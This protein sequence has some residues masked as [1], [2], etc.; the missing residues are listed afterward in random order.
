MTEVVRI[1]HAAGS[2]RSYQANR[3]GNVWTWAPGQP[4]GELRNVTRVELFRAGA[5]SPCLVLNADG[6][7]KSRVAFNGTT[8][9]LKLQLLCPAFQ[10]GGPFPNNRQGKFEFLAELA[11]QIFDGDDDL[12]WITFTAAWAQAPLPATATLARLVSAVNVN[13]LGRGFGGDNALRAQLEFRDS[14]EYPAT[15]EVALLLRHVKVGGVVKYLVG[16]SPLCRF[17]ARLSVCGHDLAGDQTWLEWVQPA[18]DVRRREPSDEP[19]STR[20]WLL[21]V[22]QLNGTHALWNDLVHVPYTT[23]LVTVAAGEDAT[24]V[25]LINAAGASAWSLCFRF[26]F[27][28]ATSTRTEKRL[29]LRV[30]PFVTDSAPID[31]CLPGLPLVDDDRD[32]FSYSGYMADADDASA[33]DE[34]F[35]LHYGWSP[36]FAQQGGD[37]DEVTLLR[38]RIRDAEATGAAGALRRTRFGALD[39]SVETGAALKLDAHAYI[40][41]ARLGASGATALLSIDT[42]VSEADLADVMPGAEDPLPDS[43]RTTLDSQAR[44]GDTE[45]AIRSLL[46]PRSAL[47][48][49]VGASTAR[50]PAILE[51]QEQATR[52]TSR[53]MVLRLRRHRNASGVDRSV[54]YLSTEPFLLAKVS[55]PNLVLPPAD[56]DEIANWSLS[57]QE[58]RKWEIATASEGFDLMLPPQAVGEAMEKS[59]AQPVIND[60]Q[61]VDFRFSAPAQFRLGSTW[62]TQGYA[63]APWNLSRVLGYPGQ[64]APGAKVDRLTF[65][66]VY[67]ITTVVDASKAPMRLSLA[68]ISSRLGAMAPPLER[69]LV[70]GKGFKPEDARR[71]IFL[72]YRA[73]W[74]QILRVFRSRLAVLELYAPGER[75]SSEVENEPKPLALRDGVTAYLREGRYALSGDTLAAADPDAGADLRYPIHPSRRPNDTFYDDGLAGGFAW[76]FESHALFQGLLRDPVSN[77][78][79]VSNLKFSS[80]GAW[81]D[82]RASFDNKRTK[83]ITSTAMGRLSR[84]TVERVGRIGVLWNR[85]KHVIVYERTVLPTRQFALTQ[86]PLHGRAVLRKVAEYVEILEP[87]RHYPEFGAAP[88]SRGFVEAVQF[89]TRRILVDSKWGTDGPNGLEIP[90]WDPKEDPRIYPRPSVFLVTSGDKQGVSDRVPREISEPDRLVFFSATATNLDDRTDQWPAYAAVDYDN[91]PPPLPE[92]GHAMDPTDGDALLPDVVADLP[93]WRRFTWPLQDAA[94]TTNIVAERT[95]TNALKARLTHVSMMRAA[96]GRPGSA[97]ADAVSVMD[98]SLAL[99]SQLQQNAAAATRSA[100]APDELKSRVL[101]ELDAATAAVSSMQSNAANA[102]KVLTEQLSPADPQAEALRRVRDELRASVHRQTVTAAQRIA[103]WQKQLSDELKGVTAVLS[104]EQVKHLAETWSSTLFATLAPLASGFERLLSSFDALFTEAADRHQ[105]ALDAFDELLLPFQDGGGSASLALDLL[106]AARQQALDALS[107]VASA[108]PAEVPPMLQGALA[109]LRSNLAGVER[110]VDTLFGALESTLEGGGAWIEPDADPIEQLRAQ[111]YGDVTEPYVNGELTLATPVKLLGAAREALNSAIHKLLGADPGLAEYLHSKLEG[112]GAGTAK[113]LSEA[114]DKACEEAQGELKK[115]SDAVLK[116]LPTAADALTQGVLGWQ[117]SLSNLS[118]KWTRVQQQIEDWRKDLEQQTEERV[119]QWLRGFEPALRDTFAGVE[120]LYGRVRSLQDDLGK[121]PTFQD[122]STTLRLIRA[123]GEGP[124]LPEM[125]FNRERIAYFFDDYAA[126]VRSSPV[127]ALVNRVGEDLKALGVRLPTESFLDRI[128]PAQLQKF[129]LGKVLPDFSALKNSALFE[130]VKLPAIANDTVRVTQ[131]FDE[132]NR[133]PWLKARVD[134]P[135]HERS[136][137]FKLGPLSLILPKANFFARAEMQV[138]GGVLQRMQEARVTADWMLEFGGAPLV[139]FEDTVLEFSEGGSMRFN[140]RPDRIRM[141]A[142]LQWLTDLMKTYEPEGGSGLQ[143]EMVYEGGRPVGVACTL[144][145]ALP[146]LG[147]GVFAVSGLQ[148]GAGLTL[149]ADR[150][151]GEFAIGVTFN[152]SRKIKPFT[153]T[154]A[155]LNGG[156]WIESQARYLTTS[157]RVVSQVSVGIVA[158]AG[159]EFALGPCVGSVYVQFGIFVEFSSGGA[160][161]QTLS[162]GVMLLV[163]GSVVVFSIATVSVTLLLQA[164]YR[165][166]GSLTGY[167]SLSVSIRISQFLKLSFS[168]QVTYNLRG[169]NQS[170]VLVHTTASVSAL[171]GTGAKAIAAAKRQSQLFQ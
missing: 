165:Q 138:V 146:P 10:D 135:M 40:A 18:E 107:A 24:F 51:A 150:E 171:Q 94:L 78:A 95:D 58:G 145:T 65:E 131:G 115:Y 50:A 141:D 21:W 7:K 139:T 101:K 54:V 48:I 6:D 92:A 9:A 44:A 127:A 123:V 57:E 11:Q 27:Q 14:E 63:E 144:S 122:P 28:D 79:T 161:G 62:F 56:S 23:S 96:P 118:D 69:V 89:V 88:Q 68:E 93:G 102:V 86:R 16:F 105:V 3:V 133:V 46:L 98:S 8:L 104:E 140:I 33:E 12:L 91:H 85:S 26:D 154:I 134:I 167:G 166:D 22:H 20:S 136:E 103:D 81:G 97:M 151:S 19:V 49:P 34:A 110:R 153:L 84:I 156:G 99:L 43:T 45:L 17:G 125:R 109:N 5:A 147:A 71:H 170:R 149:G 158:G 13:A 155:F 39:L 114:I 35:E 80:L 59:V 130:R 25:P 75:I 29:L 162:I 55:V 124:L 52:S 120:S 108:L 77:E 1:F 157:R 37:P 60:G 2:G 112:L 90:L 38:L 143:I 163:R 36:R 61:P 70:E 116:R 152:I 83:I 137:A 76:P 106:D 117:D 87:E 121:S 53:S 47:I 41:G 169:G 15:S 129:D 100:L 126:A 32:R 73:Q 128:I 74:A 42:R 66:L 111:V 142:A 132:V 113:Q 148:L 160:T 72:Y 64:R 119:Q 159:V 168:S 82:Q 30:E 4:T 31:L 164:I 67:G